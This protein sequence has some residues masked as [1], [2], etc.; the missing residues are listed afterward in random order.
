MELDRVL[1]IISFEKGPVIWCHAKRKSTEGGPHCGAHC[2]QY[3]LMTF[4]D[5]A[6]ASMLAIRPEKGTHV[7]NHERVP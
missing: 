3:S 1:E 6:Q 7:H 4:V 5:N 2:R